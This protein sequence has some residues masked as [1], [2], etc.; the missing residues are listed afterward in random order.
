MQSKGV[1]AVCLPGTIQTVRERSEAEDVHVV[2]RRGFIAGGA[3][4]A[5]ASTL[6]HPGRAVAF[7]PKKKK[8]NRT[9][10]LTYVFRDGFPVYTFDPPS[11]RTLVTIE[12]DGFYAQEWTFGEHSGTHM[13]V[14][15]HFVPEGRLAPEITP[16]ELLIPIVVIDISDR[17]ATD[18]DT[19]VTV[20]DLRRFERRHG[21]IP[22][23]AGVFMDSGWAA[24][25]DDPD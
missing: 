5:A 15:G 22:A 3:V 17:A 10:D 19:V 2:S 21:R 4:A 1:I 24:K 6:V 20:N 7:A 25:V 14:P 13:D 11:R 12:P 16:R 9:N 23:R 18:P 8:K